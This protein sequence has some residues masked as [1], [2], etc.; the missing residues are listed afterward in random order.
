MI[1]LFGKKYQLAFIGFLFIFIASIIIV[2]LN[3][4]YFIKFG[5]SVMNLSTG[6]GCIL[7]VYSYWN[8]FVKT[9]KIK[10]QN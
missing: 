7:F 5:S 6:M 9:N 3:I 4:F 10:N 2:L 8:L 1:E